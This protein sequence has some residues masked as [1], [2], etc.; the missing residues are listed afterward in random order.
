MATA[1]WTAKG[2]GGVRVSFLVSRR[3]WSACWRG[4]GRSGWRA[5]RR[6]LAAQVRRRGDDVGGGGP[7]ASNGACLAGSGRGG[8]A[9]GAERGARGCAGRRGGRWPWRVCGRVH[10]VIGMPGEIWARDFRPSSASSPTRVGIGCTRE[11]RWSQRTRWPELG[12]KERRR[13]GTWPAC[14]GHGHV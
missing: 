4:G 2:Q 13:G 7:R 12:R 5:R 6:G 8:E 11:V 10:A 3:F 1:L 9:Q 14:Y